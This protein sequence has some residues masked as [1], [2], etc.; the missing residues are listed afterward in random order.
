[1]QEPQPSKTRAVQQFRPPDAVLPE[2]SRARR[3]GDAYIYLSWGG[4]VYGPATSSEV[5]AGVRSSW[6]ED[7]ALFWHDGLTHWSPVTDFSAS[8]NRSGQPTESRTKTTQPELPVANRPTQIAGNDR[9]LSV[10][11]RDQ[12]PKV[13]APSKQGIVVVLCFALLAAALTV[14]IILLLALI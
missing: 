13:P 7:D 10:A 2:A 14:G 12:I 9:R 5:L 11:G 1:M 4:V 8:A 6:F 3:A